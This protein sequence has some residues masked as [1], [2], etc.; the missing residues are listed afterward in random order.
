MAT[1][2]KSI[3]EVNVDSFNKTV[4]LLQIGTCWS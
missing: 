4:H 3:D 1:K 2:K